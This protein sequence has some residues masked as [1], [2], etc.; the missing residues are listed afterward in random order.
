MHFKVDPIITVHDLTIPSQALIGGTKNA[1]GNGSLRVSLSLCE[2]KSNFIGI[3]FNG[4]P[5]GFHMRCNLVG[6]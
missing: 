2:E 6:G 3:Q 1:F 5:D 4:H